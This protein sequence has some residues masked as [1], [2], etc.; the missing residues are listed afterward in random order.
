M[1][2]PAQ[3]KKELEKTK[4]NHRLGS[5]TIQAS[6]RKSRQ[7]FLDKGPFIHYVAMFLDPPTYYHISAYSFRGNYSFLKVENVEISYSFRIMAFFL[8]HKLNSYRGN[9]WRGET[10]QGR[11]LFAEIWYS[12]TP[13]PT[14]GHSDWDIS[15]VITVT[16][17]LS[18]VWCMLSTAE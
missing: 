18:N 15:R 1:K 6:E 14:F 12:E 5:S 16:Y 17:S 3:K 4:K 11:K 9:Y 2:F 10:I 8:L 7:A 13:M